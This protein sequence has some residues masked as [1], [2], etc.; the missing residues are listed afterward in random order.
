VPQFAALNATS[1]SWQRVQAPLFTVG[2]NP[3][4]TLV[5][6][7]NV[8]TGN[9]DVLLDDVQI[10]VATWW[11]N[12]NLANLDF[13]DP[14]YR[15]AGQPPTFWREP[16]FWDLSRGQAQPETADRRPGTSGARS[17]RLT[18]RDGLNVDM[19]KDLP[20]LVA[21][22]RLTLTGWLKGI[23]VAGSSSNMAV[24]IGEGDQYAT[25]GYGN[26]LRLQV[27]ID[28]TWRFFN[29]TYTVPCPPLKKP[30]T[31]IDLH[32][33]GAAGNVMLCDDFTATIQ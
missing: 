13:E 8:P 11:D 32:C 21:G 28:G 17:C 29:V 25:T 18:V 3:G 30:Y 2:A 12:L 10:H 26:N 16:D 14:N 27:P 5:E 9:A 1:T 31:R 15:Y 19:W 33:F 24:I 7:V 22:D 4:L 20:F 23:P 6:F